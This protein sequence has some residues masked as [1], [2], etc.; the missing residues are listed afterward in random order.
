MK[1]EIVCRFCGGK[2]FFERGSSSRIGWE[3]DEIIRT[4]HSITFECKKCR[5]QVRI[6]NREWKKELHQP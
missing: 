5:N 4:A 2:R 3:K 1:L 6:E